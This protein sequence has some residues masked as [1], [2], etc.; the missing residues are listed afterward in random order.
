MLN[1]FA[2]R[3][4][5][6]RHMKQQRDPIGPD[7]DQHL[8]GITGKV[9]KVIGAWGVHGQYRDRGNEV[10]GLFRCL[11]QDLYCLGE[12]ISAHPIHPLY[13]S[14]DKKPYLFERGVL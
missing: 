14:Y 11:G 1:L 6:P 5:N 4:T 8:K 3:A 2:F 10:I 9:E 13:Q 12:T 7:N